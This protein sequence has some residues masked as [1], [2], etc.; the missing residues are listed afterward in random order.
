MHIH[1]EYK[2]NCTEWIS[3][4]VGY[5]LYIEYKL[6]SYLSDEILTCH[7]QNG[8]IKKHIYGFDV[9]Y[10][11]RYIFVILIILVIRT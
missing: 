9:I 5:L 2:Q 4:Y 3:L 10:N 11:F 8:T 7:L 6:Y 1:K